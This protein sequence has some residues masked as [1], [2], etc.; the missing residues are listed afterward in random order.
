MIDPANGLPT[1]NIPP[2]GT[3]TSG[4]SI[5]NSTLQP[6]TPVIVPPPTQIDPNLA[7]V[8]SV[9]QTNAEVKAQETN[10]LD[11]TQNYS[12]TS[13]DIATLNNTLAGK[14]AD[15]ILAEQ[16][17]GIPSYNKQ[18]NELQN[19]S[20]QKT[21]EY[22]M[23]PQTLSAGG[24]VT[25]NIY[26]AEVAGKQRQLAVD[27]MLNNSNI[28]AI[29]GN[30]TLAQ[31]MADK[32]VAIKYDPIIAKLDAQNKVLTENKFMLSR[33]DQK[34]AEAKVKQN[35]QAKQDI[36]DK[37]ASAKAV[38]DLMINA[39][40]V[41]PPDI[42]ANAKKIQDKGGTPEQ[43]A[44]ALGPYGKD[45]LANE[46]LKLDLKKV[47][48][49]IY[50]LDI[51][52]NADNVTANKPIIDAYVANIQRDPKQF[53]IAGVPAKYKDA[54][55]L[56]LASSPV[57]TGTNAM[58]QGL[59]DKVTSIDSLLTNPVLGVVVGPNMFSR[60]GAGAIETFTG[61]S[62][63][64]IA[65]I[66]QLISKDTLDTLINL[67]A[68]G[69]TLGALSDQ[70]RIMLRSAATKISDWEIKDGDGKVVG[71]SVDEN[72]F[73]TELNR[74]KTLTEQ[75]IERAGGSTIISSGNPNADD[76]IKKSMSS[77]NNANM[78][79]PAIQGGFIDNQK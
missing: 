16:S 73:K 14:S 64:F 13:S 7:S 74:L 43:V 53:T 45:Y 12:Q 32:A 44:M 30:I 1:S 76:Y 68:Q 56:A 67:K 10:Q 66:N 9:A 35:E 24:V 23:T 4:V 62:S 58:A 55:Q 33:A 52:N 2:V 17:Q 75:A 21:L 40:Q 25:K 72:S 26:N 20:R 42:M 46:K 34:L 3:T 50:A 6:N 51:K 22:N 8:N 36:A 27:I 78:S 57:S 5:P 38:S 77:F 29:Q 39:S 15:Q 63:N 70:E 61:Q 60:G 19:I 59:K 41:A 11:A 49:E 71:Y 28:Q 65:G 31:Q 69:G 48:K 54:V 79:T 47:N 18:L 37:K